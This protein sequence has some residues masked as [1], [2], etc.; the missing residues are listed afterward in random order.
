VDEETKPT[1]KAKDNP[2]Y[3]LATFHG[4][5]KTA[6]DEVAAKNR[7]TWNRW[8]A[9]R[10][11][12]DLRAALL[13]KGHTQEELTPF[14]EDELRAIGSQLGI[15]PA[16]GIVDFSDTEFEVL[17]ANRF[18]FFGA[19]SFV[20]AT[21]SGDAFFINATFSSSSS[22]FHNADFSS[23]IFSGDAAFGGATF[24]SDAVFNWA[25]LRNAGFRNAT[26]SS[27]AIFSSATFSSNAFF[28]NATFG[29]DAFFIGATFGRRP[30]F[31]GDALFNSATFSGRADFSSARFTRHAVFTN[32]KMEGLTA[33][34]HATFN[35]PPECSNAKLHEGTT[36]HDVRWPAT[37]SNV[38]RARDFLGAYARLKLEMD[39]LKKH[40]DE[41]DFFALEQQCRR[42]ADGFWKG[43]PIAIYGFVS[44]YGRSYIRPLGLLVATVLAGTIIFAA[45]EA[46][47]W[48]PLLGYVSKAAGISFA[49]TLSLLGKPLLSPDVMLYKYTD[50]L[51][52]V[53]TL[54]TILGIAF[55]FLFGLGIR[56]RFRMK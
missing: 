22:R 21:F 19:I 36:W 28:I 16:A 26:F 44:D 32:A 11:P 53:A 52:A 1:R 31:G 27:N 49:N 15:S 10:I 33:F 24:S 51:K 17:F 50:W 5:P 30:A 7:V 3:K 42:A 8:M 45:H 46:G 18:V 40:S 13:E 12:D 23:A 37:P 55:L 56:N 9:S 35:S 20:A 29:G 48:T 38:I 47:F 6:H 41:L 14:P 43:L 34:D 54:Q 4:V 25:T 39:R 2:W